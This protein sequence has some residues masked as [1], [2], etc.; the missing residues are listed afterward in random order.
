M[1]KDIDLTRTVAEL[2]RENPEI[3][4]I[5]VEAG[6]KEIINPMALALMGKTMTIPD[7]AVIKNIPIDRIIKIFENHGFRVKEQNQKGDD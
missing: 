3:K 5:M 2:V 7:G 1:E 6:F 4:E